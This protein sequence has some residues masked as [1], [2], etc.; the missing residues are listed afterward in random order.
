MLNSI[1]F[2]FEFVKGSTVFVDDGF[3]ILLLA[4]SD[5]RS[6]V[7][8]QVTMDQIIVQYAYIRTEIL[9]CLSY[10]I[11]VIFL[12]EKDEIVKYARLVTTTSEWPRF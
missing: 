3:L 4:R 7:L 2:T 1:H 12:T 11:T 6:T 10:R 5:E 8:V 9:T